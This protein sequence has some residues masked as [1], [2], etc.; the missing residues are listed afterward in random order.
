M[1]QVQG[2]AHF[3]GGPDYSPAT[4]DHQV[5]Q[6]AMAPSSPDAGPFCTGSDEGAQGP[7][8]ESVGASQAAPATQSTRKDPLTTKASMLEGFLLDKYPKQQPV[9]QN[10]LLK[11]V[12]RKYRQHFPKILRRASERMELVFGLELM[13]VDRSRKIYALISK[14]NLRGDEGRSDEGGLPKSGLLMVLLGII[15]VYAGWRHWIFGETKRLITKDLVQGKYLKYRPFLWGPRACAETNKMKVLEVLAK[16]LHTVASSFPDFYD[17]ALRDQVE[18]AGL[19]GT[20]RAPRMAEASCPFQGQ[21]L[22]LL[23]HLGR[24]TRPFSSLLC[25]NRAV[26]LLTSK[27]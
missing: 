23:P 2:D 17:E 24:G 26:R 16:I 21:V 14:L 15:L 3:P 25:W 4:G 13:D 18:S 5:L 27:E 7:E 6:G 19:R 22:Q 9:T 12:S 10:T 1:P 20:A 11:V 8:E